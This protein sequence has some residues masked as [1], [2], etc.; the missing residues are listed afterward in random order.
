MSTSAVVRT[1]VCQPVA[2]VRF[3]ACL[4]DSQQLQW[5]TGLAAATYHVFEYFMSKLCIFGVQI[6]IVFENYILHITINEQM[7]IFKIKS[8]I[9]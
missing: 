4:V 1:L 3:L 7:R 8:S 6:L 9:V 5:K 2:H